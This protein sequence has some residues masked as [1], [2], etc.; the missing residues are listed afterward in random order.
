MRILIAVI[1]VIFLLIAALIYGLILFTLD[2]DD[3]LREMRKDMDDRMEDDG[4]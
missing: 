2:Y 1:I 4:K 3:R